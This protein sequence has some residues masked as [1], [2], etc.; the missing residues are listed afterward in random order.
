MQIKEHSALMECAT[1]LEIHIPFI[2]YYFFKHI[3]LGTVWLL[4]FYWNN[5]Y[6]MYI[7]AMDPLSYISISIFNCN[8][9]F[10]SAIMCG[11]KENAFAVT[12]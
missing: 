2:F 11:N 8:Q 1:H 7:R 12:M 5:I 3:G 9:K 6:C 4:I 10:P